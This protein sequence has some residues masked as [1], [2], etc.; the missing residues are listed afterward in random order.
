MKRI[1]I[2]RRT[3]DYILIPTIGVLDMDKAFPIYLKPYRFRLAFAFW[4]LRISIGL[5]K[6]RTFEEDWLNDG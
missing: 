1:E 6:A 4:N 5:G 2:G 3:H